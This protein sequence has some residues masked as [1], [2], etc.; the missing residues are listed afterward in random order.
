IY[1]YRF[2][3]T[4]G[5]RN[6]LSQSTL[7]LL[8]GVDQVIQIEAFV[9]PSNQPRDAIKEL[10]QR[11]ASASDQ[12]TLKIENP[13][14][15]PQKLRD[16]D[17]RNDGEVVISSGERFQKVSVLT[18]QTLTQ[19]LQ[20]LL[21]SGER[22]MVF[23]AGH[24]ER[25]PFSNANFD[26]GIWGQKLGSQGFQIEQLRPSETASIPENTDVLVVASPQTAL[27]PGEINLIKDWIAQ[28]G[29]LLWLQDSDTDDSAEEISN[30]LG[31]ERVPGIIVDPNTQMLGLQRPD[32]ALV[33]QYPLHPIT[34]NLTSLSLYPQAEGLEYTQ[35]GDWQ[36]EPLLQTLPNSWNETGSFDGDSIQQGDNPDEIS[37]PFN[38]AYALNRKVSTEIAGEMV[39]VEQRV[40]V[41]GDTDFLSN[42]YIGNGANQDIAMNMANW[43]S[44]DDKLIAVNPKPAPDIALN[45]SP[46]MQYIIGFGFLLV[47]PAALLIS[48]GRIW[49][50]RRN[51]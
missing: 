20:R 31:I 37:G 43:L 46:I 41:I 47:I 38:L 36:A 10:L 39:D 23:L 3:W 13:D 15:V 22:W 16:F 18:E 50:L 24:G 27:L 2:D 33:A 44:H 21:R 6:S 7:V 26:I 19:A 4:S 49:W 28:G 48:G 14:L 34:K 32:F 29:D 40:I 5:S 51:A 42:Q 11:Y 25:D 1:H 12:I 9:S 30:A 8:D 17:I 35:V 45:L